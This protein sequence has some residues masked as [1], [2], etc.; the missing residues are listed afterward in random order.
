[1]TSKAINSF[2]ENVREQQ[3]RMAPDLDTILTSLEGLRNGGGPPV[4]A[5]VESAAL[6]MVGQAAGLDLA[7]LMTV[8]QKLVEMG[9]TATWAKD[10]RAAA[11]DK[12]KRLPRKRR[13]GD[14]IPSS[15]A[16]V[17]ADIAPDPP[18]AELRQAII[19]ALLGDDAGQETKPPALLRRHKAGALLLSWLREHG[20]FVRS[21]TDDLYYF[22]E[23]KRRLFNLDTNRWAAW[24]YA[25]SG[26]NPASTDYAHLNADCKAAAMV[27][28]RRPIVRVS[29]WDDKTQVL[30]VSRLDGTVYVLDGQTIK[31]EPNGLHVLFDDDPLWQPYQPNFDATGAV[32]WLTNNI[33]N[34]SKDGDTYGLTFRAWVLSSFFTELCPSRPFAVFLGEKGS[35]KSMALRMLLKLLFGPAAEVSG[36]PDKPDGFTAAAAAAHV[37]VLD[38]LDQ[39]TGWLR[40]K[41]ARL[42]T[43]ARDHYRRL[44]T[45]NEQGTVTYRTWLGFTARTPDTLKRDDLADRLL[46]L[47][48]DRLDDDKRK[49]EGVLLG[50]VAA[51]RNDW[52]G[53]V[54]TMLNRA[55]ASI[56]AGDLPTTSRLRMADW[57]SLGRLF[58]CNED[59]EPLWNKAV[60][61]IKRFQ[62]DFLL[63]DDLIVE[64]LDAWMSNP[65]NHGRIMT[66]RELHTALTTVLF[67]DKTP[68]RDWPKGTNGFSKR[69]ASIR[70]ELRALYRVE[71]GPGEGKT[72]NV[73]VYR[74]WPKED[75]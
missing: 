37:L 67:G 61:E 51:F 68:P 75:S 17:I 8:E 42:A 21:E 5:D 55:V 48:V 58:A 69:L 18:D 47:P 13:L 1:M 65:I 30:R 9:T 28:Q 36:V 24:L 25:L 38:N 10:W 15:A 23:G 41:L 70:R 72:R 45:S 4:R 74:F 73:T 7:D 49:S 19:A 31:E 57:E 40:D 34:W 27:A 50:Q 29:A 22:Y 39:F 26:A 14:R 35:G 16:C 64:G 52:W 33:P 59:N 53:D 56:R 11:L 46:F 2:L 6:A 63:Q 3:R 20:G 60:E 12:A 71:W 66:A 54:L 62:G 43:G 44:Y 32:G